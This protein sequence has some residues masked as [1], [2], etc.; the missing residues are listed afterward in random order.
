M[1]A[2]VHCWKTRRVYADI[3][4]EDTA[5]ASLR[6]PNGALGAIEACTAAWPGWQRPVEICGENGSAMLEDDHLSHW[7]FR[8]AQAGDEA[9]RGAKVDDA[10]RSG[11]GAPNAITYHG[12]LRQIQ[13]LID[14]LLEDRPVAIDGHEAS[15]A[16]ALI[17]ALYASAESGAPVPLAAKWLA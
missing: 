17:R 10:M 3:E 9:I 14:S 1:P 15:K 5:A 4:A 7:D 16:V 13:D 11:A 12:H 8:E 2:E 6:F